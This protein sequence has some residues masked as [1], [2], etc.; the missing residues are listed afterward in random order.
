MTWTP[1]KSLVWFHAGGWVLGHVWHHPTALEPSLGA[2]VAHLLSPPW[3]ALSRQAVV[4]WAGVV[5]AWMAICAMR[6][7]ARGD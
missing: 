3:E 6:Q 7:V 4:A 1:W 2:W 5:L